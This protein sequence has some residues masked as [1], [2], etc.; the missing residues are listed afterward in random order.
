MFQ[1]E[2]RRNNRHK[3]ANIGQCSGLSELSAAKLHILLQLTAVGG[4]SHVHSRYN[5]RPTLVAGQ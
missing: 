3:T 4:A 5:K 1:N 2:F